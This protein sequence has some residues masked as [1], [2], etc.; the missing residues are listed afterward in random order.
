MCVVT[1]VE[2]KQNQQHIYNCLRLYNCTKTHTE[3][4]TCL[5]L[6]IWRLSRTNGHKAIKRNLCYGAVLVKAMSYLTPSLV[7]PF[8]DVHVSIKL[9]KSWRYR[10]DP[11]F[12]SLQFKFNSLPHLRRKLQKN[13]LS[14]ISLFEFCWPSFCHV[15]RKTK[16]NEKKQNSSRGK[17][18]DRG[19][20]NGYTHFH[21][22][23]PTSNFKVSFQLLFSA[24]LSTLFHIHRNVTLFNGTELNVSWYIDFLRLLIFKLM[25]SHIATVH[26]SLQENHRRRKQLTVVAVRGWRLLIKNL[27]IQVKRR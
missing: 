23:N 8:K 21:R 16:R 26:L 9:A 7:F 17:L 10:K 2:K 12:C 3:A 25:G 27:R 14:V 19:K 5:N 15:R 24:S 6:F 13:I 22:T 20:R 18:R 11:S 4:Y 1:K